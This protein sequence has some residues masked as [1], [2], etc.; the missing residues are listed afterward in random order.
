MVRG[1]GG[2]VAPSSIRGPVL[3]SSEIGVGIGSREIT[4]PLATITICVEFACSPVDRVDFPRVLQFLPFPKDLR[5][6]S[7]IVICKLLQLCW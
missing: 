1:R 5:V 4:F 2:A 3:G 6:G 7:L